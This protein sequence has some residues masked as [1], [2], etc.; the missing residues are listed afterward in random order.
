MNIDYS[1]L[2]ANVV[3]LVKV[4][5][6]FPGLHTTESCG[7][8]KNPQI[9]QKSEGE[10][11]I[12]F[13]VDHTLEGLLALE[14]LVWIVNGSG[15]L[16][17]NG[18]IGVHSFPPYLNTPG[19][20][21][22]FCWDGVGDPGKVAETLEL[23]KGKFFTDKNAQAPA[24]QRIVGLKEHLGPA[25]ET[26]P[27]ARLLN[28]QTG[29]VVLPGGEPGIGRTHISGTDGSREAHMSFR[30]IPGDHGFFALE[31]LAWAVGSPNLG[32]LRLRAE[33]PFHRTPGQ[34]MTIEWVAP[35]E[36]ILETAVAMNKLF[37]GYFV[38]PE[39]VWAAWDEDGID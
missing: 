4:M 36:E 29:I 13:R 11:T 8:H 39:E 28:L 25:A 3:P 16:Q 34:A 5:N 10:F 6:T 30:L 14:F 37:K 7:G 21:H 15:P 20:A 9:W 26:L 38:T 27:M 12:I 32:E 19:E 24:G 23:I 2:E 1:K 31:F 33:P 18:Q 17:T 35:A 22:Y